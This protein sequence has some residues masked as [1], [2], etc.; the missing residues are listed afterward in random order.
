MSG[1]DYSNVT[2]LLTQSFPDA[3][4]VAVCEFTSLTVREGTVP[5]HN[6]VCTE[7]ELH[8]AQAHPR[9]LYSE[10]ASAVEARTLADIESLG[11][12]TLNSQRGRQALDPLREVLL[13]RGVET[14]AALL[15]DD[16][17]GVAD[18]QW[19]TDMENALLNFD[20]PLDLGRL[21]DFK[22]DIF[23]KNPSSA[24]ATYGAVQWNA[25][26]IDF[27][28]SHPSKWQTYFTERM[29]TDSNTYITTNHFFMLVMALC[30]SQ[31][32]YGTAVTGETTRDKKRIAIMGLFPPI[33]KDTSVGDIM[34]L[35][36][37]TPSSTSD[38]SAI[39]WFQTYPET[40][41]S[42]SGIYGGRNSDIMKAYAS[43]RTQ[44]L[45][46]DASCEKPPPLGT[47]AALTF[48]CASWNRTYN[49][50]N[51]PK[52]SFDPSGEWTDNIS[53]FEA[54]VGSVAWNGGVLDS[55]KTLMQC[56]SDNI[57][58]FVPGI[59][60]AFSLKCAKTNGIKSLDSGLGTFD[61]LI[62]ESEVQLCGSA[63]KAAKQISSWIQT[64]ATPVKLSPANKIALYNQLLADIPYGMTG[65]IR[66][67]CG[68][69]RGKTTVLDR[70]SDEAVDDAEQQTIS[71]SYELISRDKQCD[72]L[73]RVDLAL[74]LTT[75]CIESQNPSASDTFLKNIRDQ[76]TELVK[77]PSSHADVKTALV[78]LVGNRI[79]ELNESLFEPQCN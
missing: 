47:V 76:I 53:L 28:C 2:S 33:D 54:L 78:N 70:A 37:S 45:K 35:S 48:D 7:A 42:V 61:D 51:R 4:T 69:V 43:A 50:V 55:E 40:R 25:K 1:Q 10:L 31:I 64:A 23:V 14:N 46:S 66:A 9:L 60:G 58:L 18:S 52:A 38:Q 24:E 36:Y 5:E 72:V 32:L 39:E 6:V 22:D 57:Q 62:C 29:V 34:T 20:R 13:T 65:A 44:Q 59:P 3:K 19:S 15:D 73:V 75:Y 21:V 74:D 41:P 27:I 67:F 11:F 12:N 30:R 49:C 26:L 77:T 79:I 71:R 8:E 16:A 63:A 68:N 17:D 56:V